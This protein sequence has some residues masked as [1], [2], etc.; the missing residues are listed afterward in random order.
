MKLR[1]GDWIEVK[2][3]EEILGTLTKEP[4]K[5]VIRFSPSEEDV[6]RIRFTWNF[7]VMERHMEGVRQGVCCFGRKNG[8]RLLKD[9]IEGSKVFSEM[10]Q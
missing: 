3:K 4:I 7:G 6:F 2:S 8:S 9:K 10:N 1:A 5:L